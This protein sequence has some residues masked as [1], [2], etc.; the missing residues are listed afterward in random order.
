MLFSKPHSNNAILLSIIASMGLRIFPWPGVAP[1]LNP[2]WIL[3]SLVYWSLTAPE[4]I[5]VGRAWVVGV[6]TDALT[7]RM[8]GQYALAYSIVVY[9]CAKLHMRIRQ[10][11]LSQQAATIFLLLLLSQLLIFWTENLQGH[12]ALTWAYWLPSWVGAALWPAF[13]FAMRRLHGFNQAY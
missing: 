1:L 2:D 8:L 12:T 6:L 10:F 3:M 4:R 11:P 9:I 13:F 7:G 5:G